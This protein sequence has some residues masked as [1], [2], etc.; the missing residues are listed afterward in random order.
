VRFLRVLFDKDDRPDSVEAA[1]DRHRKRLLRGEESV[2]RDLERL[3]RGVE[4]E[5]RRRIDV[6]TER[7]EQAQTAGVEVSEAWLERESRYRLLLKQTQE[8]IASYAVGAMERTETAQRV[9][10]EQG[11]EDAQEMMQRSEIRARFVRLPAEQVESLAGRMA[12]GS[13]LAE[14]FSTFG[15]DAARALR[16]VLTTG[17]ALGDN[18]REIGRKLAR[19]TENLGRD[20]AVLIARTESIRAYRT[21]QIES[22][23]ANSDVVVG[24][25]W[26]AARQ[27]R[28]C[29]MCWAM[30]GTL[31][32]LDD[33]LASHPA[34]RCT[35]QPV[36]ASSPR[37][38]T[39]EEEFAKLSEREQ[40]VILGPGKFELYKAGSMNLRD[41]VEDTHSARW[42]A[43]RR[44]RSLKD[45]RD[46]IARGVERRGYST[47]AEE[48]LRRDAPRSSRKLEG[49]RESR[50]HPITGEEHLPHRKDAYAP[51]DSLVGR[52]VSEEEV[53]AVLR[54]VEPERERI[55]VRKPDGEVLIDL[56]GPPRSYDTPQLTKREARATAGNEV[57]HNHPP[58][59]DG[60][61]PNE[62][63][64]GQD[65]LFG[66]KVRPGA[67]IAVARDMTFRMDRPPRGWRRAL[68]KGQAFITEL[69]RLED[70]ARADGMPEE[71]VRRWALRTL[72]QRHR[73]LYVEVE[74]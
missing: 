37:R 30:H 17:L 61:F 51:A 57:W 8:Q 53:K 67:L 1:A 34:C 73:I 10:A 4:S 2:V 62:T 64:S 35:Q 6:L 55:I 70:E 32:S 68:G 71:M 13:P 41:L 18:P 11:H 36:T 25:R 23:R 29:P 3:W 12:D 44:V 50:I 48:L 27:T 58:D 56:L 40:R 45:T 33:P 5:L 16:D 7:I 38:P 28:T 60:D 69:G 22:Y 31:H 65:L 20:R 21:A 39:G 54:A 19:T 42:G 15:D 14:I 52:S 74:E 59:P 63:L 43:G 66:R 26:V 47:S 9:N 72:C 24:W 46:A 49:G